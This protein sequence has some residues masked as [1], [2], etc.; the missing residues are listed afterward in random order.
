MKHIFAA[1]AILLSLTLS[2]CA[3]RK[4]TS[5]P[6]NLA[7]GNSAAKAAEATPAGSTGISGPE[8]ST[9]MPDNG[10]PS[11]ENSNDAPMGESVSAAVI[12]LGDDRKTFTF[13]V[14]DTFL[15][16]LGTGYE[17][18]VTF[19]PEAIVA[20]QPDVIVAEGAQG[21]F[22]ALAPGTTTLMAI[23]EPG[24]R[25][26]IPPCMMPTVAFRVTLVVE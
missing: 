22:E 12:V 11:V 19:D 23:G 17:W 5:A 7:P 25:K 2:A 8:V 13:H 24:C 16:D 3:S 4:P 6:S 1:L 18:K 21:M 14:G 15:L 9:T 26:A 20:L 10:V